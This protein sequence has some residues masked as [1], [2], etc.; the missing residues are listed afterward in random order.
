M[1]WGQ[2]WPIAKRS[3]TDI[4]GERFVKDRSDESPVYDTVVSAQRPSEVDDS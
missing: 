3:S 1:A 2:S 4:P